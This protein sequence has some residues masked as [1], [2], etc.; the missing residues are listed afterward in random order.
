MAV[1]YAEVRAACVER[2]GEPWNE[3][4]PLPCPCAA[5]RPDGSDT[6]GIGLAG[7]TRLLLIAEDTTGDGAHKAW[8]LAGEP[9]ADAQLTPLPA[10]LDAADAFLRERA[11]AA[12]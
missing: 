5:W 11:P 1:T 6:L 4:G 12:P 7:T 2:W 10:A 8:T 9:T 3:G